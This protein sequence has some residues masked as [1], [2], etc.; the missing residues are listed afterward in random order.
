MGTG[1]G[2]TLT[3]LVRATQNPTSKLL[4]VCLNSAQSQWR[5]VLLSNFEDVNLLEFKH[6][7]TAKRKDEE[8]RSKDFNVVIV[9]Y[10]I[11]PKLTSLLDVVNNDW[12]IILD[13]SHRIKNYKI[14]KKKKDGTL[15][16]NIT[17][18]ALKLG[19]L[20][21]WKIILTAT[22]TQGNYGGYIDYFSQLKFLGYMD[23]TY[24]EFKKRYIVSKDMPIPGLPYPIKQIVG[25]KRVD[26]IESILKVCARY[27]E[28]K[29][30]DFEPQHIKVP[31]ERSSNYANTRKQKTYMDIALN[32]IS[33][34][35]VA[36]KTLST[37]TI[38][39]YDLY[40]DYRKYQ[41]NTYKLDWLSDFLES[42]NEVVAIFYQYNV[43]LEALE[44]LMKKL[45]KR[46]IIINGATKDAYR[47]INH[48]EY[49]VVL[50][51]LQSASQSLD[52][53]QH[54]C[55]IEVFYAMPESSLIYKQ[56]LGRIY[57]DGQ[58]KVPMYYYLVMDDTIEED[59]MN[60]IESKIEFS[61]EVLDKLALKEE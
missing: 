1:T 27:Y 35:R 44:A 22:P 55:H 30:G 39:G 11:L 13:E 21:P 25:Y 14:L 26:E 38:I 15:P 51:Q 43:E 36:L 48:K 5:H 6:S 60:L 45:N 31:I 24:G 7:W 56:T 58:Q 50:G 33:R 3:S 53:L 17:L 34:K 9:N 46:Y 61:E 16:T 12:T 52:G 49:D 47:E 42:T 23:M 29:F 32:N 57:R 10:D 20:T 54:K 28:S 40:G 18:A 41:D 37:G 8:I 59:I 2:K 19:E 4:I